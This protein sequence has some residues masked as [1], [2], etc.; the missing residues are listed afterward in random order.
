METNMKIQ[1]LKI[2]T[3]NKR[4]QSFAETKTALVHLQ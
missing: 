1:E 4:I 2:E 3:E